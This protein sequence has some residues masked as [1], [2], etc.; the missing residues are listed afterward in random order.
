MKGTH[1]CPVTPICKWSDH[2][3]TAVPQI[4][5]SIPNSSINHSYH[6]IVLLIS[7]PAHRRDGNNVLSDLKFLP[8]RVKWSNCIRNV[9]LYVVT[10]LNWTPMLEWCTARSVV[11]NGHQKDMC[12]DEIGHVLQILTSFWV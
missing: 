5:P 2:Q 11:K 6:Y 8:E 1:Q 3:P 7:I 4:L 9:V 12:N 10:L